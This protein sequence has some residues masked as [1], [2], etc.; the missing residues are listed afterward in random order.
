[1]AAHAHDSDWN[2]LTEEVDYRIGQFVATKE[3]KLAL[4]MQTPEMKK[5]GFNKSF[6]FN[7]GWYWSAVEGFNTYL[8]HSVTCLKEC[9]YE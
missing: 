1:M 5:W 4:L 2:R 7:P 8:E 3:G 9:N 6:H